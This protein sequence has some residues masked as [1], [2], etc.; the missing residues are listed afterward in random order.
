MGRE[1]VIQEVIEN[2]AK[3]QRP[4]NFSAWREIGLSHAQIGMLFMLVH[5]HD[6]NVKQISE[7]LGITKSAITQL[8]DPLV[9][10]DLVTRQNDPKDRRIVRLQLTEKGKKA[11][12]EVKKLK[13]AGMRSSLNRLTDQDLED[14]AKIYRKI[15]VH[16]N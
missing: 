5:H 15:T 10:K 12:K 13:F 16:Q 2:I 1:E 9:E 7:Y 11:V 14:L 3:S 4:A 6:A 8:M